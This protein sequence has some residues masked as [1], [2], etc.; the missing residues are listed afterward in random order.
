MSC[1]EEHD[2]KRA[3]TDE[4]MLSKLTVNIG[5]FPVVAETVQV[6]LDITI[7]Y[8]DTLRFVC[9]VVALSSHCS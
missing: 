9:P 7:E 6:P 5:H 8:N 3:R 1:E 4:P 2:S